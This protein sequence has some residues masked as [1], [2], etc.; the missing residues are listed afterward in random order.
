MPGGSG[1]YSEEGS[2]PFHLLVLFPRVLNVLVVAKAPLFR[3]NP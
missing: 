2:C 1:L 3:V